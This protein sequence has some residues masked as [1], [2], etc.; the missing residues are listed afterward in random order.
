MNN[1]SEKQ[2]PQLN[3]DYDDLKLQSSILYIKYGLS[4][5]AIHQKLNIS[6][7]TLAKWNKAECWKELRPDMDVLKEYKAANLYIVSAM[8]TGEIA[9]LLSISE[10]QVKC[11]IDLN[12]WNAARLLS[13]S[14]NAVT[15]IVA[16]F[17]S[18]FKSIFPRESAMIEVA[19]NEYR[20]KTIKKI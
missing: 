10:T 1:Q 20:K 3:R 11:W 8:N 7:V 6:M 5:E 19:Q 9:Q 18:Y 16:D 12:G 2:R 4:A 17:C 14:Q 13:Q 15:D